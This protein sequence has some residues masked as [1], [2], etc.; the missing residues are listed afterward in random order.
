MGIVTMMGTTGIS[1][2]KSI[3][4]TGLVVTVVVINIMVVAG[5][6][7]A[8]PLSSKCTNKKATFEV[9]WLCGR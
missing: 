5:T 7:G 6:G 8:N 1:T 3:M 9:A 4:G 2:A